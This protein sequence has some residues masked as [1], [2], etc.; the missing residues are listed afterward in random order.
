MEILKIGSYGDDVKEVQ[1]LLKEQGYYIGQI[2]SDFGPKT[3][4]SL[5]EFQGGHINERGQALEVDGEVGKDTWWALK[6]PSGIK[7]RS[8]IDPLVPDG[9]TPQ[10][11][12]LLDYSCALYREGIREIPD[13]SN[14]G[15]GVDKITNGWAAPWCAMYVSYVLKHAL[16]LET[17]GKRQ[18]AVINIYKKAKELD[19]FRDKD[20]YT[21][22]PGDIFI[23]LYKKNGSFTGKGHTGFILRV[24]DDGQTFNTQEGNAGNRLATK[25]RKKSQGTLEGYVNFYPVEEQPTTYEHGV[26]DAKQAASG[27]GSTR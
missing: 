8:F 9:L 21:P 11:K 18:A 16:G 12:K 1:R 7:Q 6:N 23:M 27:M 19:L 14:A 10:R 22:K 2:D 17:F 25:I 15:D 13:G 24:A 4:S 3:E 26:V 5:Q 20:D